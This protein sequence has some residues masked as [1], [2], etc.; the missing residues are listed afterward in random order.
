MGL[1]YLY[2]YLHQKPIPCYGKNRSTPTVPQ[3]HRFNP[4]QAFEVYS[5]LLPSRLVVTIN[6]AIPRVFW[7]VK[8]IHCLNR[9]TQSHDASLWDKFS[10]SLFPIHFTYLLTYLLTPCNTNLHKKLTG[11][12]LVKKF[13]AF[14][15]TRRCTTAFTSANHLSR[16]WAWTLQSMP[17][18]P[19]SWRSIGMC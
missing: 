6:S 19:T 13:P 1:I 12:Q 11:S 7:R 16:S 10:Y 3:D 14:Y 8:N 18:N 2:L 5:C 9:I 15:G 17:S 4:N